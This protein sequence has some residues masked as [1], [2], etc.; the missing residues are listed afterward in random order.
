MIKIIF[1]PILLISLAFS[2]PLTTIQATKHIGEEATVCGV[3]V[4]SYYSKK[5]KGK[6]TFINLD[7]AYPN[8]KFTIVIWGEDR[9]YF[10]NSENQFNRKNIYVTGHINSYKGVPQM[11]IYT[12][13]QIKLNRL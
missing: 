11:T 10:K 2:T 5:S 13:S 8:Q 6:P 4:G 1:L 3:V 12:P 9:E 7:R